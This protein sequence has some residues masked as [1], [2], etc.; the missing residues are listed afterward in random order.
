M[1]RE[2]S[3]IQ[4][5]GTTGVYSQQFDTMLV[6]LD[7]VR[8]LID[9]T[10]VRS[11]DLD[12]LNELAEQLSTN[13]LS[14]TKALEDADNQLE[15]VSQRVNLG[16]VALKK[17]KNRTNSLH[18]GAA[19]LK[20]EAMRLQEANVQGALNVTQQ[21]AEQSR[22]AEK[23]ANDT[24]NIL[25]DAERYR[26]NTESLLAKNSATV[27]NAQERSVE[28][29]AKLNDKISSLEK[30]I[31]GLNLGMCGD[32]VTECSNVCG[33]AGCGTCGGISCDAGAVT[34]ANQ[35]LD[36][37]KKQSDKIKS[38]KDAAEQLFRKVSYK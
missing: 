17:L 29:I 28:S 30:D 23:M 32:N 34:K 25:A 27:N 19:L 5:V 22:Q 6:S 3:R 36:V 24:T 35:A 33:G 8:S 12:E 15:N 11:Q 31:P 21:M 10:T 26:K 2:A 37:A 7:Q 18:Q 9:N 4:K 1:I 20:E 13:I 16:D 14:S 38:H